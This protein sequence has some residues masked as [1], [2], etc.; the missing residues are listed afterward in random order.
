MT[1]KEKHNIGEGIIE[2]EKLLYNLCIE[3]GLK[4]IGL[5]KDSIGLIC[6]PSRRCLK[7]WLLDNYAK[8][9]FGLISEEQMKMI[10][11]KF[12]AIDRKYWYD[13]QWTWYNTDITLLN[14][15]GTHLIECKL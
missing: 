12:D 13:G 11:A 8:Y 9:I 3:K 2:R 6:E 7:I 4:T 1:F 14:I 5:K 15:H 10:K